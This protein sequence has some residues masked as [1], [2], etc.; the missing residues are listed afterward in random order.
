MASVSTRRSPRRLG[1]LKIGN[2]L[3]GWTRNLQRSRASAGAARRL[4]FAKS[5]AAPERASGVRPL[6]S[7][8]NEVQLASVW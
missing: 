4:R 6:R 7:R 1:R 5:G 8:D 2:Y 3:T